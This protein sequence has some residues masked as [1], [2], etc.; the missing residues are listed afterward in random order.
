VQTAPIRYQVGTSAVTIAVARQEAASAADTSCDP[1]AS[2]RPT[3]PLRVTPGS[4]VAK[5]RARGYLVAGIG[6]SRSCVAR[7]RWCG[8][9]ES[10][11]LLLGDLW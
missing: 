1:T 8:R 10:V 7:P 3:G 2:L 4:F 11:W 6:I 5:I 9:M